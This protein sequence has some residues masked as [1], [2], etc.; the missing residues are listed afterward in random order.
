MLRLVCDIGTRY[1]MFGYQGLTV[2]ATSHAL[3]RG[4]KRRAKKG[5]AL[6][7]VC[8]KLLHTPPTATELPR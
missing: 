2:P 3:S 5:A 8:Q 1:F 4:Y 7:V 6:I